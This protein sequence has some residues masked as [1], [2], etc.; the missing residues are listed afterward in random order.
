MEDSKI[1]LEPPQAV[2][3]VAVVATVVVAAEVA[4]STSPE[5]MVDGAINYSINKEDDDLNDDDWENFR[6]I[7]LT[8]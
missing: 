4:A 1:T 6:G 3:V 2:N 7:G 8:T 5:E